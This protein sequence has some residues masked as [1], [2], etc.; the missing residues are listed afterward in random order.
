MTLIPI[1]GLCILFFMVSLS[2]CDDLE[3]EIIPN[4]GEGEITEIL[5]RYKTGTSHKKFTC[6]AEDGHYP[7]PEDCSYFYFCYNRCPTLLKCKAG[8]WYDERQ[9]K[10]EDKTIVECD[11][12]CNRG[13]DEEFE[14]PSNF[15]TFPHP[16]DCS[17][18]YVCKYKVP[19]MHVCHEG[20]LYD[21]EQERCLDRKLVDCGNR[22][23][24]DLELTTISETTTTEAEESTTLEPTTKIITKPNTPPPHDCKKDDIDCII[25]ETGDVTK[26]FDCPDRF[27]Y[28]VHRDSDKLFIH[29]DNWRPYIKTCGEHTRFSI[30]LLV[31]V[32]ENK[33]SVV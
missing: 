18:Y 15:G 10:C 13:K 6:P 3:A 31:C 22:K 4:D 24:K 26:W 29:C 2:H 12:G 20:E 1:S 27:G 7:H 28:F 8:K 17:K 21:I 30:N 25:D 32:H 14:C 5:I 11:K 9:Q 19:M 33:L 23:D 16:E